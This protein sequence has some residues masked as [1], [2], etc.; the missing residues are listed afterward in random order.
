MT[1]RYFGS[2][3]Y[4]TGW[5]TARSIV[6]FGRTYDITVK[7]QAYSPE[8]AITVGQDR[9]CREYTENERENLECME[10]L[11][12][13]Y[14]ADAAERFTP[15]RLLFDTDGGCALLC[16]DMEDADEGIAVC[17]LPDKCVMDQS[18]YL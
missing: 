7:I 5:K 15:R 18:D 9:A 11:M 13:G 1:N 6:L 10:Q 16:N 3:E 14:S 12:L 4:A 17:I 8:D 2:M